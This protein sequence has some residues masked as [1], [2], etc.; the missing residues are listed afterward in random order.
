MRRGDS[1]GHGGEAE[2]A[3]A[4]ENRQI[5]L[6]DRSGR[7]SSVDQAGRVEGSG[8]I[9]RAC[10]SQGSIEAGARGVGHDQRQARTINEKWPYDCGEHEGRHGETIDRQHRSQ[11][12]RTVEPSEELVGREETSGG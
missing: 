7:G 4:R 12:D 3:E 10:T 5:G 6:S 1:A 11:R 9:D 2:G 8:P